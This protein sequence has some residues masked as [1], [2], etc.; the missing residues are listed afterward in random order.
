MEEKKVIS[1]VIENEL[2]E[3]VKKEATNKTISLSAQIRQCILEHFSYKK[4]KDE[5]K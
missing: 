1:L 3:K 2:L 5:E 4:D